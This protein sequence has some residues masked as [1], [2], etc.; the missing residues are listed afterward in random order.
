[1]VSALGRLV[2]LCLRHGREP[3]ELIIALQQW[4]D[5]LRQV[6]AA[7]GGMQALAQVWRYLLAAVRKKEE[8]PAAV[9]RRLVAQPEL[10]PSG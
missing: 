10:G 1:M 9:A 3:E 4:S 5:M 7:P 2:L 8:G 6:R